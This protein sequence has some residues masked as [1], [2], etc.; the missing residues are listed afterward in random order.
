[1]SKF[2][3]NARTGRQNTLVEALLYETLRVTDNFILDARY[4]IVLVDATGKAVTITLPAAR[5]VPGRGFLVKKIDQSAHVV[6]VLPRLGDQIDS[7]A[8]V[9]LATQN[10][11]TGPVSDG[12]AWWDMR[13][14]VSGGPAGPI[15]PAGLP[16]GIG[17]IGPTGPAGASGAT[18]SFVYGETPAPAGGNTYKFA[19]V[20]VAGTDQV[21]LD[22]AQLRRVVAAPGIGEYL[23]VGDTITLGFALPGGSQ[24]W[25]HYAVPVSAP[26]FTF[27]ETPAF[28][29]GVSYQLVAAPINNSSQVFV[30]GVELRRVVAG[31]AAGEYTIAG[32][33]ITLGFVLPAGSQIWAHYEHS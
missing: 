8:L 13:A 18:V 14:G 27:Y 23:I 16:G 26:A 12:R 9:T 21:F 10:A 6:R 5:D 11:T 7:G 28:L 22:G 3:V 19:S 30:D 31:A 2:A 25:G 33:I 17:P 32:A 29:G 1:M 15:G 24:L 4:G 20:P